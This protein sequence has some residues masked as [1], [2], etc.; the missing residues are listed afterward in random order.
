MVA[1]AEIPHRRAMQPP[2]LVFI[3][4][5]GTGKSSIVRELDAR[6]VVRVHPTWTSRPRRAEELV[7][8]IEHHFVSEAE[9]LERRAA[10]FFLQSVQM[11]GL[12]HW[13]GLPPVARSDDGRV[14]CVMLRAPLVAVL[15]DVDRDVRVYQIEAPRALVAA[16]LAERDCSD[17]ERV[18]RLHDNEHEL[19][20]G[21]HIA[22]R[23]F[24]NNRPLPAVVDDVE[25][26]VRRDF[27]RYAL[28][29]R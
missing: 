25:G 19:A 9:F 3:G 8:A 21:A 23:R 17:T 14:D 2:L 4:P 18:A 29:T 7:D 15:R 28:E 1:E 22:D 6:G 26:A 27:A 13:Y 16:R 11:F 24:C 5:S 10:G 20:A 12:P